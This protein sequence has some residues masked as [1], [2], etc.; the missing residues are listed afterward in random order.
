MSTERLN[1]LS[2]VVLALIGRGGAGAHDLVSMVRRG[3]RLYWSAAPSKMYAEP[4]RLEALGYVSARREAGR[5]RE[6]TFYTLTPAGEEALR[7]WAAAPASF[8]RI[9]NDA[10]CRLLAAHLVDDETLL[11]SLAALRVETRELH[12]RLD[13]GLAVAATL[14]Q[15]ERHLQLVHS[16]GRRL[17]EAHEA[18][19]DEVEAELGQP[20]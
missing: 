3:A 11:R 4:K 19:L 10:V 18:W 15:R 14:P 2:Y 13:E 8:P 16:L 6:R 7:E 17:V 20:D 12:E 1:P 5:T 9:Y